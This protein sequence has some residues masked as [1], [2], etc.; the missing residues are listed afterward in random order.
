MN[1]LLQVSQSGQMVSKAPLLV[2]F[3][4]RLSSSSDLEAGLVG[5]LAPAAV[6]PTG[7]GPGAEPPLSAPLKRSLCRRFSRNKL[8]RAMFHQKDL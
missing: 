2:S 4:H 5:F 1:S 6:P 8:V 3:F 7:A